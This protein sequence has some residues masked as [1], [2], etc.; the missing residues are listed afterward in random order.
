MHL[1]RIITHISALALAL[2]PLALPQYVNKRAQRSFDGGEAGGGDGL[3][4]RYYM[5]REDIT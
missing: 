1:I 4:I 3:Y 5:R 2:S